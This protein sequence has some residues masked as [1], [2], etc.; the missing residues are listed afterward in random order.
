MAQEPKRF[1]GDE[2]GG[3]Q[4]GGGRTLAGRRRVSLGILLF[5]LFGGALAWTG[6]LLVS[7]FL[8]ALGCNLGWGDGLFLAVLGATTVVFAGLAAAA[9]LVAYRRWREVRNAGALDEGLSED[10]SRAGVFLLMGLVLDALFC[11]T[12]VLAGLPPLFLPA[13]AEAVGG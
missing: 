8:V 4:Y 6:H 2:G 1:S 5:A 13:C 10:G 7:Y 12:I 3:A 11:A 9:A